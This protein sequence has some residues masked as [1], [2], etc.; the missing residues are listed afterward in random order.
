MRAA[1]AVGCA[2]A[3]VATGCGG[4]SAPD[5]AGDGTVRWE[6]RPFVFAPAQE[7]HD[8]AVLGQ[9]TNDSKRL[10]SLDSR[11]VVVRDGAGRVL[12]SSARF[13]SSWGHPLYGAFQRPAK[14]DQ[15]EQFRLGIVAYVQ[16]G[17]T[18]PLFVSYRMRPASRP[19][20]TA[21]VQGSALPLPE[22]ASGA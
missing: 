14:V 8:R 4:G 18:T 20:I 17:K 5:W 6:K 11:K 19:P 16:P 3:F 21:T 22:Q 10:L 13:S 12:T 7:P 1:A 15:I 2:V 9:I